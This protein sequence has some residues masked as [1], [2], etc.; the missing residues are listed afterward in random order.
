MLP[1]PGFVPLGS[2]R[3]GKQ[4][5]ALAV[6]TPIAET[7]EDCRRQPQLN[8]GVCSCPVL[9]PHARQVPR[10]AGVADGVLERD[11]K[12]GG[13]VAV[14]PGGPFCGSADK[15][16]KWTSPCQEG[17][18]E[19]SRGSPETVCSEPPE[20]TPKLDPKV[21]GLPRYF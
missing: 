13:G 8:P 14:G 21:M 2:S 19:S 5:P 17:C 1:P 12:A 15:L 11:G 6:Y 10:V 16:L 20:V 7:S 9:A 18:R 3:G 4:S